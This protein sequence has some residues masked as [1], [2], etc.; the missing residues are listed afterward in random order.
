MSSDCNG[1]QGHNKSYY[2]AD[3]APQTVEECTSCPEAEACATCPSQATPV[4]EEV[5]EETTDEAT[6]EPTT[7]EV[8]E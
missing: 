3:R 5:V 7:E 1:C 4:V 8:S 6:E 2:P